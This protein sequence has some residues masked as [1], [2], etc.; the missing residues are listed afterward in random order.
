MLYTG[1][2]TTLL[3][4]STCLSLLAATGL[5][6][7]L[8]EYQAICIAGGI[9]SAAAGCLTTLR[10]TQ[11]FDKKAECYR[12]A[13]GKYRT[14]AL[15]L[16][17][18]WGEA[19]DGRRYCGMSKRARVAFVARHEAMYEEVLVAQAVEPY[20]VDAAHVQD[21]VASRKLTAEAELPALDPDLMLRMSQ[22][23]EQV[24]SRKRQPGTPKQKASWFAALMQSSHRTMEQRRMAASQSV[25]AKIT[26][27]VKRAEQKITTGH[28]KLVA[29]ERARAM[30]LGADLEGHLENGGSMGTLEGL[31]AGE[32][33]WDLLYG[34]DGSKYAFADLGDDRYLLDMRRLLSQVG[35]RA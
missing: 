17:A 22:D 18:E 9:C 12:D 24:E 20:H 15:Q 30:K 4:L 21:W 35:A 27:A 29:K 5:F 26:A 16:Q 10:D 13:E 31:D 7:D 28:E 6:P 32:A 14:L 33:E 11:R 3:A 8:R 2:L 23:L 25:D 1:P 19:C 34:V